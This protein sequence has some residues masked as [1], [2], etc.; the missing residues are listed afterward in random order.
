MPTRSST[1]RPWPWDMRMSLTEVLDQGSKTLRQGLMLVPGQTG[2]LVGKKQTPLNPSFP[3]TQDYDSAPI[4]RERTFMFRPTGGAGESIQSSAAD[5][6]YHYAIDCWVSGGLFGK[7]PLVHQIS[8][9]STGSIRCFVEALGPG[10]VLALYILAGQY[11]L[12][13]TDDT[14]AGQTVG[15]NRAGTTAT[16]AQRFKG[17]YS[18]A[19]D[20]LYVAWSD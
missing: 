6:R 15:D 19:V 13:R 7:G 20:A 10:S 9:P 14:N 5:H 16:D 3:P 4:Y 17:A 1:R 11:L 12:R 8:P 2:L 18:G